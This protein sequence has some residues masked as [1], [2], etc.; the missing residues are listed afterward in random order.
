MKKDLWNYLKETQ[1]PIVLYGM[2]NGADKIIKV[3]NNRGIPFK[4]VFASD[5]FVREKIF[6]GFKVTDFSSLQKEFG[7][8]IVLLCFGSSRP[9]VLENIKKI[10]RTQ[11]LYA[12]DVP[13]YG[14]I[15]FCLDYAKNNVKELKS[16][17]DILC[18]ERSKLTF[19]NT[20]KYKISGDIKYLFD[21]EVSEDEPY[22]NF[23]N[24]DENEIFMDLGA[25]R[26]D[27]VK[28]F[29]SRV[30]NHQKIYAVE[31]DRKT[32]LKLTKECEGL[33]NTEF[34][35]A[36]ISDTD[37]KRVF[38]M[39]SSRGSAVGKGGTEIDCLCVDGILKGNAASFIKMDIEG[40]EANAITGAKETILKYKPKMLISC[41]HRSEDLIEI[42][43][44][45]LEIRDDYKVYM[46]HFSS[47]PA[48]DTC[49][50]FV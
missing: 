43:K 49:Y 6:H 20:V 7:D 19:E 15:L 25:Y 37:G 31:P 44:R 3:L 30:K 4:G 40:E 46:R 24:L 21:C 42:P 39:D 1:K 47:L 48:W 14:D 22:E 33:E 36:C 12:P 34:L 45:V 38:N 11:E 50:Y 16:V 2:G 35:N 17:Y 18:D 29:L 9:E 27:T 41:Y 5:G 10:A 8:M 13:V 32:F 23:L 26:G 28:D